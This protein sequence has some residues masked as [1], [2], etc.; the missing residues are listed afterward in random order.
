MRL[1]VTGGAGFIGSHL[2]LNWNRRRPQ[3]L[4]LNLDKL[5]Y[6][7]DRGFE[8]EL[9]HPDQY[10]FQAIDLADAPRVNQAVRDFQPDG[11]IHLA[12]ES[13]VDN[14][15]SGPGAFVRSNIEG[16]FVLLE[17]ARAF[18]NDVST[19]QEKAQPHHHR[20]HH[21]STDEVFGM[22]PSEGFFDETSAYNPSSPY[23]A[24]KAASDHL[25]RAWGH[26]Y[27]LNFTISNCS[28]NFGPRQH[29]EKLIPTVI[30][31]ALKR[32]S[33]P[34]YG[35][36]LNVRDWLAVQDHCTDIE[37]VFLEAAPGSTYCVG[38]NTEHTNIDL[39]HKICGILNEIV[40]EKPAGGFESL[41][42]FVTDRPGHDF[43]YAIDGTK[44]RAELNWRPAES[45]EDRLRATIEWYVNKY[46][47]ATV[48]SLLRGEF[49]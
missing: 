37:K 47:A 44:I 20:F 1:L 25:V 3:D 11:I 49:A 19:P 32:N 33:I 23:S 6:A 46:A 16:T 34:V 45:F 14:S 17:A 36:G 22:L 21:V 48:G 39:V 2:I 35:Q 4:I 8:S 41:I 10:Q 26:T 24:T 30:R 40:D 29:D 28:N 15:I 9:A 13:H 18:W 42:T 27:G 31:N 7:S 43:R 38:G 12:A 5:G